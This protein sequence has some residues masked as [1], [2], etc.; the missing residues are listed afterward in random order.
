MG[1]SAEFVVQIFDAGSDSRVRIKSLFNYMQCSADLHSKS[2]GTSLTSMSEQNFTWVYSRF[3]AA[4]Y[5][6]PKIYD[7]I[8][9]KTWRSRMIGN[10]V[11]RDFA[12][13]NDKDD[14]IVKA[15]SSLALIDR[16][17]R[18]PVAIPEPVKTQLDY[19]NEINLEFP[20]EAADKIDKY[21]YIYYTK[22]KYDDIDINGHMNNA[23]Y[24]DIFFES[25]YERLKGSAILTSIDIFFK[26]EINYGDDL[27]CQVT[28]LN[29]SEYLFYHRLFN[30]TKERFS[31]YAVTNWKSIS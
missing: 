11:C 15:T 6:Y 20:A 1:E 29:G 25:I 14:I 26:G 27:E 7:K 23:S 5:D 12:I 21:D 31:A 18:K 22:A 19:S 30:R 4:V 17:S 10:F 24:A 9:C 28:S 16:T 13:N 8:Y 3:Y 2:L